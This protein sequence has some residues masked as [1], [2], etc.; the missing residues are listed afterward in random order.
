[1]ITKILPKILPIMN[2]T[3][4]I[5]DT[6]SVKPTTIYFTCFFK[7]EQ[8]QFIYSTG[9]KVLPIH[10]NK[11]DK[12]LESKGKN[13]P[14]DFESIKMQL[15]RYSSLLMQTENEYKMV[16][17]AFTPESLK[18][19][20]DN[21]FKKTSLPKKT[22]FF[23]IYDLFLADK[24]NNS[25]WTVG[26]KKRYKHIK[27]IAERF[28]E[29]KDYKL[30]F[31]KIN[32]K[33]YVLFKDYCLSDLGHMNN[34]Y[35][36]NLVYLKTFMNWS[37]GKKYTYNLEYKNFNKNEGGKTIIKESITS[38]IAL[39]LNDLTVLMQH[40]FKAKKL[41]HTRDI[42]VFQ[43]LTGMRYGELFLINKS[44]VTE[45]EIILKETKGVFKESRKIPLTSL[46]KYILSKYDYNLKPISNQKQND[47]IKDVFQ[48]L[49][50]NH[51]IEKTSTREREII[52]TE[53]FFYNRVNT[54][55]ARR[56]FITMM[57]K[58]GISDKLIA[59]I[60]G[61]R[62]LATLNKYYQVDD[63]QKSDAVNEVFKIEIPLK[64]V[65]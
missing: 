25:E 38:Q 56:T 64:K 11:K 36:R 52:R 34:T 4:K 48:E 65:Q 24:S 8:K 54:H 41:E 19:A 3:F 61:H 37:V 45:N 53:D 43:C 29:A 15:D 60:S 28:E 63:E 31:S 59:S 21:E 9:E 55:T 1:M 32:N 12:F 18:T 30:T 62:D 26:T 46:S 6:N 5:K 33:F 16:K 40:E 23:E 7:N 20:L 35:L 42:F 57:K 39:T 49:E 17:E 13:K 47:Y 27:N 51:K 50:Y 58:Q 14:H 10:W 22:G 44:N 2:Y